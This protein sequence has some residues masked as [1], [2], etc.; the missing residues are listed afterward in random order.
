MCYCSLSIYVTYLGFCL[1]HAALFTEL[2]EIYVK[3]YKKAVVYNPATLAWLPGILSL[4]L[5]TI[6][7]STRVITDEEFSIELQLRLIGQYKITLIDNLPVDLIDM[8]KSELLSTSDLSSLRNVIV[9]GYKVPLSVLR[10]FNS[11]LPNG[12]VHNLYGLTETGTISV[13]F[14]A[15]S[16]IDMVG[17]L[18]FGASVKIV[19]KLG[20]RC[21]VGEDGELHIKSRHKIIGYYNN[22]QLTD[23]SLDDEGY[24]MTGDIGHIDENGHLYITDRIR[25]QIL[26]RNGWIYPGEIEDEL[27][28]WN[29]IQ[30]VCVIGIS[31]EPIF[32]V[33]AAAIVR[34][35]ASKIT[36]DDVCTFVEGDLIKI[37]NQ[38]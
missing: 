4:V 21:G 6:C 1:T 8:L 34:A 32:E 26:H 38:N 2:D 7:G 35:K 14:P 18:G 36:E 28:K 30:N 15:F 5:G 33:P 11:H 24:F 23:Q 25:N 20:N 31:N 13:D 12:N 3:M 22:Q 27:L 16:G 37:F 10:E 19:D 17:C 9:G 29:E